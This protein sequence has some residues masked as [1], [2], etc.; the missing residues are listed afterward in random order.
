M[1][2]LLEL[3]TPVVKACCSENGVLAVNQAM[4]VLGGYGYTTDFIIEQLARDVR[5]MSIYEGTTGIQAQALLG[6]EI[7]RNDGRSW[8]YLKKEMEATIRRAS[9][10]SGLGIYANKLMN[11]IAELDT[12][13]KHLLKLP[14]KEGEEVFLSDATIFMELFGRICLAWQWL[15]QAVVAETGNEKEFTTEFRKSQVECMRFYFHYELIKTDPLHKIL[16][17]DMH[18]TVLADKDI[19]F[20]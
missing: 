11:D 1:A 15:L 16:R 20:I 4:Q 18:V 10:I 8:S 2:D 3:L 7:R 6:R 14:H 12:T 5:I 9:P 19:C 13:I 17:D